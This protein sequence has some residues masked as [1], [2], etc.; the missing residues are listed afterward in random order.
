MKRN[1]A[2]EYLDLPIRMRKISILIPNLVVSC[3]RE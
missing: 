1:T 3:L 2:G